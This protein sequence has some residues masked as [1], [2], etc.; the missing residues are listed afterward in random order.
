MNVAGVIIIGCGIIAYVLSMIVKELCRLRHN[1]TLQA[2]KI[3]EHLSTIASM[4]RLSAERDFETREAKET[5]IRRL[6]RE[7]QDLRSPKP[8][9]PGYREFRS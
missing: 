5:E 2:E 6:K 4:A 8:S 7:L 9:D 1:Q 3:C